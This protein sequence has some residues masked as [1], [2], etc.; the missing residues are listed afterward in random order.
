M[1]VIQLASGGYLNLRYPK[2]EELNIEDIAH[3]LSHI[4]RFGGHTS[5]FLSVAQHSVMVSR[6]VPFDLALV[7]LLHDA[8]EFA[9]GDSVTPLKAL[10]PEYK[11]IEKNMEQVIADKFGYDFEDLAKVKE[12]DLIALVTEKR[13]FL[14]LTEQDDIHWGAYSHIAPHPK[15]ILSEPPGVARV[16]FLRRFNEIM[17]YQTA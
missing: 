4:C 7:G 1:S 12:A 13:D 17:E 5:Q 15:K 3:S 11:V 14:K 9:L 10:L 2:A 8:S 6:L 16:N